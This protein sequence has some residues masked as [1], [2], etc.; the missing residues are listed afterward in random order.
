MH[1][2]FRNIIDICCGT[3]RQCEILARPGVSVTGIDLSPAMLATA[4]AKSSG[5]VRYCEADAANLPFDDHSFDAAIISL[6]LH[7][8]SHAL[9][10]KIIREALRV[11]TDDGKLLL[12]DYSSADTTRAKVGLVFMGLAEWL[13]GA[14]H[15]THFRSYM[16]SGSID[17]LLSENG[18]S[19]ILNRKFHLGT[20]SLVLSENRR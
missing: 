10:G 19:I 11:L 12:V 4:K 14:E 6:A 1:L 7:E 2:H 8:K 16:D 17:T 3:G 9:R 18:L 15:Y 13:A 20:I 5:T